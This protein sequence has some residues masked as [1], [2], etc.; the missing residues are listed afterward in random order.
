MSAEF[1]YQKA[2][3][4]LCVAL[5]RKVRI[6]YTLLRNLFVA[7]RGKKV[8]TMIVIVCMKLMESVVS[9]VKA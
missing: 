2:D 9:Y 5:H 7:S 1:A 3:K 8:R 4:H 6:S